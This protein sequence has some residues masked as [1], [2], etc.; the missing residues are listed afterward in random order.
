[1]SSSVVLSFYYLVQLKMNCFFFVSFFRHFLWF[2]LV[3]STCLKFN[4]KLIFFFLNDSNL[5]GYTP[6]M[7]TQIDV[8]NSFF[9]F[10]GFFFFKDSESDDGDDAGSSDAASRS[11]SPVDLDRPS[12][13]PSNAIHLES[14]RATTGHQMTTGNNSNNQ[15]SSSSRIVVNHP[16]GSNTTRGSS[17]SAGNKSETFK[18]RRFFL[19]KINF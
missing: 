2:W 18:K 12:Y 3:P 5:F 19:K 1:M 7:L 11:P 4:L 17:S 6:H 8:K 16:S 10:F 14:S 9:G 15:L 13:S